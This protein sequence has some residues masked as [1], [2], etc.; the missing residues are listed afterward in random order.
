M[1]NFDILSITKINTEKSL[2]KNQA[3][4]I[5]KNAILNQKIKTDRIYSQE[6]LSL[7]LG[8]SRT[9]VREALLQLQ[10]E[11]I[12][13]IYRGRGIQVVT[14]T[15][16]NLLDIVELLEAVECKACQ[17]AAKRIDDKTLLHLQDSFNQLIGKNNPHQV[18]EFLE[19]DLY[20]HQIIAKATANDK[21]IK[22]IEG[23]H[24]QFLRAGTVFRFSEERL[25][26]I[27]FEHNEILNALQNHS[28]QEAF[29]AMLKH[30]QGTFNR[31]N[32][33]VE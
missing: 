29:S 19:H 22:C 26:Q 15:K 1:K 14:P 6:F 28:E 30:M 20:C 21:L 3:Y 8:I 9:P 5:I 10:N 24:S 12:I 13:N 16:K 25:E 27:A 17:L 33:L 32:E 23:V 4:D 7:E 2:L 18:Y 31:V 11:G